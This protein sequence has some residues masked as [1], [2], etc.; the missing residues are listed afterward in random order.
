MESYNLVSI[1]ASQMKS[2][3]MTAETVS[4][5]K[6]AKGRTCNRA[7]IYDGRVPRRTPRQNPRSA[8]GAHRQHDASPSAFQP[9]LAYRS[10]PPRN[11]A[12]R[13]FQ[14]MK[15]GRSRPPFSWNNFQRS[16]KASRTAYG[17]TM[18]GW[19]RAGPKRPKRAFMLSW[20]IWRDSAPLGLRQLLSYEEGRKH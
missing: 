3:Q 11:Q 8:V 10:R 5:R 2:P 15:T 6:A 12:R 4:F 13:V 19:M 7:D 16:S 1:V 18:M 17:V 20:T 14:K 9:K